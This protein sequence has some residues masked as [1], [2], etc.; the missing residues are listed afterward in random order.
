MYLKINQ[1]KKLELIQTET[2]ERNLEKGGNLNPCARCGKEVKN[3]KYSVHL[4]EG[5]NTILA[6]PMKTNIIMR[7]Q[8]WV[9]TR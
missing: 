2:Y 9:G 7:L 6:K 5:G 1:M 3:E 8:I 4:I